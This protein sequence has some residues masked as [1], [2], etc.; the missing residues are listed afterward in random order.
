MQTYE[1]HLVCTYL[2]DPTSIL[3]VCV[4]GGLCACL[5]EGFGF[6]MFLDILKNK[7]NTLFY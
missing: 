2:L 5:P 1:F 6:G 3:S 7:T 4:C